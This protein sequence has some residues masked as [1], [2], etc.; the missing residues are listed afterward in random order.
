[1]AA[2][3]AKQA[4]W[5]ESRGVAGPFRALAGGFRSDVLESAS[6]FVVRLGRT[7]A[8]G[9]TFSTEKRV[10]DA[11]RGRV[12]V[13]VP[14]PT[15]VEDRRPEFPYGNSGRRSSTSVGRGTATSTRP[16][17]ASITRFSVE[18]VLP[19]AG[20]LPRRT[21]NPEADSSTSLR[22]P[23]ARARKGPATPRD[24]SH[25]ACFAES[26][27]KVRGVSQRTRA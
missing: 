7:P 5:L 27:A 18:N 16:R 20:V 12:D 26:A 13:A 1:M 6:G 24:S 2:L 21:T 25:A 9:N 19:S 22:N 3:S 4:A 23:P 10:M 8:D 15:L 14:R 11:V 17:T